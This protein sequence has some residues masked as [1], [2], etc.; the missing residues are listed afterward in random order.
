MQNQFSK[1]GLKEPIL[2]AISDLKI[3]LPTE[4]QSK[5]IPLLL[6]NKCDIVGLAK[7][8]TGKTAAFGLPLLQLID[9]KSTEIQVVVLVPTRELGQ[10][11]FK[12]YAHGAKG[13]Y[14]KHSRCA[15]SRR[16][17]G[18]FRL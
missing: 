2:K 16:N 17:S 13:H 18:A 1:L 5:V 12:K 15:E 3:E 14:R 4:I 10:Q 7:T 6:E 11:I 8:G 9:S